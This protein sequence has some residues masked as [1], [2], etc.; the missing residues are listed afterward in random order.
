MIEDAN[1][2]RQLDVIDERGLEKVV[3]RFLQHVKSTHEPESFSQ[4]VMQPPTSFDDEVIALTKFE[5]DINQRKNKK[6]AP[7]SVCSPNG[8]KFYKIGYIGSIFGDV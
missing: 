1:L 4:I 2:S 3:E 5:L 6:R 8:G 7:C